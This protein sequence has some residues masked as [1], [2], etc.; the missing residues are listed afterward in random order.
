[1]E[2]ISALRLVRADTTTSHLF[3]LGS[4]HMVCVQIYTQLADFLGIFRT[5]TD[6]I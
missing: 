4:K 1:M 5:P 6:I 2:A 3:H